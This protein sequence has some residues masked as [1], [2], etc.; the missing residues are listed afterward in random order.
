MGLRK[1]L[2]L[3]AFAMLL[4]GVTA[5][6]QEPA[7]RNK[8]LLTSVTPTVPP[9]S[10]TADANKEIQEALTRATSEHKRILLV[11]GANW[12]YDCHVLDNA[13]HEGEAGK[14]FSER[15]LLVHIDIGEGER[16]AE[17]VKQYKIPLDKGV[18]AVAVLDSDGKLLYSSGEGEF[19]AARR[20]LKKDLVI[21]LKRWSPIS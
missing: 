9:Y 13:L 5:I 4:C 21:F 8:E 7:I 3:I 1:Q 10:P 15:F 17:L 20:M 19:E 12:C 11:F 14:I 6:A 16:N 18:P 2:G